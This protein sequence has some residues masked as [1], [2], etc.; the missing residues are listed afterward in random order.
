MSDEITKGEF[1]AAIVGG[2]VMLKHGFS[3]DRVAKIFQEMVVGIPEYGGFT[4]QDFKNL[5]QRE[6]EK[7]E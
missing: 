1:E 7:S 2:V 3:L 6:L 5:L 4:L